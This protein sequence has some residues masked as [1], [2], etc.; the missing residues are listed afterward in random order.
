[1]AYHEWSRRSSSVGRA[2]LGP[3]LG[4]IGLSAGTTRCPGW[5]A[6]SV[7]LSR[8]A[9]LGRDDGL[10][11][12]KPPPHPRRRVGTM[13]RRLWVPSH[14][15]SLTDTG[16]FPA[17]SRV[18]CLSVRRSLDAPARR[19]ARRA[20]HFSSPRRGR[21][22]RARLARGHAGQPDR[23]RRPER[24]RQDDAA[25]RAGGAR[26]A[27]RG[28][29]LAQPAEPACRLPPAGKGREAR[30][31]RSRVLRPQDGRAAHARNSRH[32][33]PPRCGA[34][35]STCRWT[36]SSASSRAGRGAAPRW[37]RSSFRVST[38]TCSTSRRTTSTSPGSSC[39]SA[40]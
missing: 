15:G 37:R 34:S 25:A 30:R 31:R 7:S 18:L 20:R 11:P 36:G 21:G 13:S 5:S 2:A 28:L 14:D 35:A 22:P 10:L 26:G 33:S 23:R 39:W 9:R 8:G 19:H 29:H 4:S 17:Q 16:A 38:S 6:G 1:M 40:S 27:R 32:A 3:M 12:R 24:P